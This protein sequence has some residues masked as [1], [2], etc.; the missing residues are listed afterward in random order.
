MRN[1]VLAAAWAVAAGSSWAGGNVAGLANTCNSC[2]GIAGA[3]AGPAIPSLGGL[4]RDYLNRV[5]L[6]QKKGERF[7][8]IMGRLLKS[9][10]DEEIGAL[11]DYFAGQEWTSVAL[12]TD[13]S[14]AGR[15]RQVL[16]Q[17]CKRCHGARGDKNT[18][19]VPRL[20]GQ[21]PGYLKL[22]TLK[23]VD[24]AFT[25]KKPSQD[26]AEAVSHLTDEDVAAVAHFLGVRK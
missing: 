18:D 2:H 5:M 25:A 9:Y 11:A 22:E 26:M 21:W 13:W 17:A 19:E 8:T 20:S 14:Q 3:S 12:E 4:N 23:Y 16:R 24:P 7:S 15:G 1:L 6:E 10:S